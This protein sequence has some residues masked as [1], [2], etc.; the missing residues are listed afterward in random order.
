MLIMEYIFLC[1][2]IIF[3]IS[4]G[5][6]PHCTQGIAIHLLY[7][8]A[9]IEDEK[10]DE[11]VTVDEDDECVLGQDL[12]S[13]LVREQNESYKSIVVS[14]DDDQLFEE[15]CADHDNDGEWLHEDLIN[16]DFVLHLDEEYSSCGSDAEDGDLSP[17][18]REGWRP[19]K[20]SDV[21]SG[22]HI[23]TPVEAKPSIAFRA[24]GES[25]SG[26]LPTPG[27]EPCASQSLASIECSH[28]EAPYNT[29]DTMS[30]IESSACNASATTSV[31]LLSKENNSTLNVRSNGLQEN[32][33]KHV[34]SLAKDQTY[35]QLEEDINMLDEYLWY[36]ENEADS[37]GGSSDEEWSRKRE[38]AKRTTHF[39]YRVCMKSF[40][41][42]C[43]LM[44]H[45]AAS[46]EC[47]CKK[48]KANPIKASSPAKK[49]QEVTSTNGQLKCNVAAPPEV[50]SQKE[51]QS[52]IPV[53]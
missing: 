35:G 2:L 33:S 51:A 28:A 29:P 17:Q 11:E 12:A 45:K 7:M 46:V 48:T 36:M 1:V 19:S 24:N 42:R 22:A 32:Q 50:L 9:E 40:S 14:S 10:G 27:N 18:A 30:G 5:K 44:K 13:H 37:G 21:D 49:F 23:T 53:S 6:C 15:A 41:T 31:S 39:Q 38:V 47:A 34:S 26:Q 43:L 8:K 16:S 25:V 3:S 4:I 20:D 52:A